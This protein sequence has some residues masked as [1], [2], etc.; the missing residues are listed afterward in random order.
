MLMLLQLS[1][2]TLYPQ[3]VLELLMTATILLIYTTLQVLVVKL[4]D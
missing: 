2:L 1:L 3:L 4:L